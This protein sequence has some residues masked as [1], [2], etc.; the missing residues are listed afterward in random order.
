MPVSPTY[1]LF[2]VVFSLGI[3]AFYGYLAWVVARSLSR[4]ADASEEIANDLKTLREKAGQ[5]KAQP[6]A[7]GLFGEDR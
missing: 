1:F 7:G 2:Q 4:M 6:R 3:M 5:G